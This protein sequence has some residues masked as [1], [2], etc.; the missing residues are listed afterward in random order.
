MTFNIRQVD[1]VTFGS[2]KAYRTSGTLTTDEGLRQ[3]FFTYITGN[4]MDMISCW[5]MRTIPR[6]KN[7]ANGLMVGGVTASPQF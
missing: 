3:S 5:P 7:M 6:L 4:K 2:V 1:K